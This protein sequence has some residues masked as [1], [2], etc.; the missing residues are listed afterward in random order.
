MSPFYCLLPTVG[1]LFLLSGC[2][3]AGD[4]GTSSDSQETQTRM[5]SE[6]GTSSEDPDPAASSYGVGS[7]LT[8]SGVDFVLNSVEATTESIVSTSPDEA[9]FLIVDLTVINN[10]DDEIFL[11]SIMSF[12]L[13]G[14]DS[15]EYDM[16]LFVDTKGSLDTSVLPGDTVRGQ[17]A[18]DV[19]DLDFYTLTVA[20]GFFGDTGAFTIIATDL[21]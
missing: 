3:V 14:S 6:E 17:I 10:S 8:L 20:P 18:F 4:P 12:S 5:P 16:T 7:T 21:G 13:R 15:Y 1:L 9:I 11:S 19:P 2:V